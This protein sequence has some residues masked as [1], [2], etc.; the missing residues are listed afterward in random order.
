MESA[1]WE[2]LRGGEEAGCS[3]IQ[4]SSDELDQGDL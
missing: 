2:G 3:A 4:C 1:V